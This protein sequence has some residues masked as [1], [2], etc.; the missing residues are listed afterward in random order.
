MSDAEHFT[1]GVTG[2]SFE[3][4]FSTGGRK[5]F[6]TLDCGHEAPTSEREARE[7]DQIDTMI[8]PDC[9]DAGYEGMAEGGP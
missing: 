8:C 9:R 5:Y 7:L 1:R 2:I 6:F 4:N 3:D